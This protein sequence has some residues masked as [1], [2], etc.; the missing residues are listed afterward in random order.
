MINYFEL[1]F[2]TVSKLRLS[3]LIIL[4]LLLLIGVV[5]FVVGSLEPKVSGIYINTNPP[6]TVWLDGRQV[7]QSPYRDNTI[8]PGETIVKLIPGSFDVPLMPYE[9]KIS[10][11]PGVETVVRYDFGDSDETAAGDIV[12]FEK[13]ATNETSLVAISTPDSAQLI[14]DGNIRA[15]TPHKTS[16]VLPGEHQLVFS[17]QGYLDRTVKVRLFAG[18]KLTAIVKLA[19]TKVSSLSPTPTPQTEP[20]KDE[21]EILSTPTGYLR[22]RSQASSTADE[23]GKVNPGQRYPLISIDSKTGWYEIEYEKGKNGWISN[24]YAKKIS[25]D[26]QKVSSPSAALSATPTKVPVASPTQ[27]PVY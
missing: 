20:V 27:I 5:F 9:T 15:F 8:K 3:I 24:Q 2:D 1:K 18:Y 12:S 26:S 4:G 22:V 7:G 10:L 25:G 17:S 16:S 14:I 13:N 11:V 21:V 23:V 6:S 19:K